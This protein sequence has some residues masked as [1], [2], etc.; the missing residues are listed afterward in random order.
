MRHA[1]D[2][3]P[4]ARKQAGRIYDFR[5]LMDDLRSDRFPWAGKASPT[6]E[7]R[8]DIAR[9][10]FLCEPLRPLWLKFALRLTPPEAGV[11]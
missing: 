4:V 9:L 2:A 7:G 6:T 5:L 10:V 8:E 3:K 11:I 1:Q